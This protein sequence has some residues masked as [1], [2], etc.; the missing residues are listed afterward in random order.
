MATATTAI[1]PWRA[2]YS[3]GNPQ[4]DEQHKGLIRMINNLQDAMMEGKGKTALS[5]ILND[6]IR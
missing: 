1:F 5:A 4:I 3:V 6:L 2:A